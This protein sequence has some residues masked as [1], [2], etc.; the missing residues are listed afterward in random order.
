[1]PLTIRVETQGFNLSPTEERRIEHGL[2]ALGRRLERRPDPSAILVLTHLPDSK[3]YEARLRIQLGPLG[4]HLVAG[5]TAETA[6]R[7]TRLAISAVERQLERRVAQQRGEATFGVPSRRRPVL[8]RTPS[9]SGA[10]AAPS[11]DDREGDDDLT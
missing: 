7:A 11:P 10:R 3:G 4:A 1:M 6:D 5:E 2:Q 9:G 8:Q